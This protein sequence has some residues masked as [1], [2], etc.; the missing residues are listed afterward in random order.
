MRVERQVTLPMEA[1]GVAM[2]QL[3]VVKN[4][5]VPRQP[6][7]ATVGRIAVARKNRESEAS[8]ALVR[9]RRG[10]Q[11]VTLVCRWMLICCGTLKVVLPRVPTAKKGDGLV[12]TRHGALRS[13]AAATK[14]VHH[15][16]RHATGPA[17]E[18]ECGL[19]VATAA[20][21]GSSAGAGRID[22]LL[23]QILEDHVNLQL[24]RNRVPQAKAHD[25][26][27]VRHLAWGPA[28]RF[29]LQGDTCAD[30]RPIPPMLD[31]GH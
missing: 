11:L 7:V 18:R 10:F 22:R 23:G 14:G 31:D 25:L 1:T 13:R 9:L 8:I 20:P 21:T 5:A 24:T 6:L 2:K 16:Q 27:E 4:E 3:Q 15:V 12:R 17:L 19:I 29:E 30:F 28:V 26:P